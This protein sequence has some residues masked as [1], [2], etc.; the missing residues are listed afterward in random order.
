M[1]RFKRLAL[2]FI[3]EYTIGPAIWLILI[4]LALRHVWWPSP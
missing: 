3:L 2:Q 1:A 4:G